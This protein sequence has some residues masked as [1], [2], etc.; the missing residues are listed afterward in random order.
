MSLEMLQVMPNFNDIVLLKSD[1][2]LWKIFEQK[3]KLIAI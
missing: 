1:F 2:F 3:E